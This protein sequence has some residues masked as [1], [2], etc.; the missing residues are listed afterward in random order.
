MA[1][2]S[3]SSCDLPWEQALSG[4]CGWKKPGKRALAPRLLW[5]LRPPEK[6][7]RGSMHSVEQQSEEVGAWVQDLHKK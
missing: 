2:F 5:D 1:G 7:E 6:V 4:V 3:E